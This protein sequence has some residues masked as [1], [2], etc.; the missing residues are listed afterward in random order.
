MKKLP[1]I[2]TLKKEVETHKIAQSIAFLKAKQATLERFEDIEDLVFRIDLDNPP[3][4]LRGFDY[5]FRQVRSA[6]AKALWSRGIFIG[7]SVLDDLLF[8]GF[9][10]KPPSDP[11]TQALLIIK[12]NDVHKPGFVLYP[13]G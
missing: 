8:S 2:S 13:I 7:L 1:A 9:R 11:V 12:D 3:P 10:N 6:L 4:G 5:H